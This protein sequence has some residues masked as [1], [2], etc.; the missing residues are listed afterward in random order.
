MVNMAASVARL[1][2]T[3]LG[4]AGR[5]LRGHRLIARK[6]EPR[7]LTTSFRPFH[8]VQEDL[9]VVQQAP[10][11][12]SISRVD[13]HGECEATINEQINIEYTVSYV[14][15]AM[16][17]FFDRD[18]VGLPGFAEYF[19]QE[20]LDERS[21]AQKLIKYQNL[22]GGRVK[23]QVRATKHFNSLQSSIAR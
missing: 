1:F 13:F 9:A 10:P 18:N 21:H 2:S 15:H 7:Q 4:R 12:E 20:S 6:A 8:D 19:R 11:T 17:C 14:Y 22:R 23:L 16:H 3:P 5:H